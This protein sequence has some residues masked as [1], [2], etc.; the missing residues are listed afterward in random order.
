MCGIELI[1][2]IAQ[3]HSLMGEELFPE[4]FRG[5]SE[6]NEGNCKYR[7]AHQ[8]GNDAGNKESS[9]E[10]ANHKENRCGGSSTHL[11]Q[12]GCGWSGFKGVKLW[13]R[14]DEINTPNWLKHSETGSLQCSLSPVVH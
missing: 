5:N 14:P 7:S 9:K 1:E 10:E 11:E 8:R 4:P 3:N 6:R 2:R 12:L 13:F